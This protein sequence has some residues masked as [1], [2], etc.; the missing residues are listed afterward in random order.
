MKYC[1]TK[2]DYLADTKYNRYDEKKNLFLRLHCESLR[3][4]AKL[5]LNFK[6][7]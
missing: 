5:N 3:K 7:I 1:P 2:A 4:Y 6:I